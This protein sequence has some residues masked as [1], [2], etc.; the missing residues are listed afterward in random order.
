MA[1]SLEFLLAIDN[2]RFNRALDASVTKVQ[3]V[4]RRMANGLDPAIEKFKRLRSAAA[5]FAAAG[6]LAGGA[7]AVVGLAKMNTFLQKSVQLAGEQEKAEAR[8]EAVLRA[9]GEAAGFTAEELKTYA[10]DLQD[11]TTYGDEVTIS[12]MAILATF[13]QIKGDEFKRATRAAQ[14]MATVIEGMS[15]EGSIMQIG[16]ALNDPIKGMNALARAGVQFTDSQKAAITAM[17]QS[18]DLLGAQKVLLAELESQF[19]GA[20]EAI[21]GTF[22]GS[23]DAVKNAF[24]DLQEE[25]GF[26]ITQNQFFIEGLRLAEE[27][28]KAFTGE[29]RNSGPEVREYAKSTALSLLAMGEAG[30]TALDW[31]YRGSQ[32][33]AG[34]FQRTAAFALDVSGGIFKII[35]AA[36]VLT[37]FLGITTGA[38][39]D[40]A[41]EAEAAFGAAGEL[42]QKA[43]ENFDQMQ[44]GAPKIQ[45][46]RD[47]IKSFREEL[48]SVDTES[49]DL[50][51]PADDAT[52][53]AKQYEDRLVE[54]NGVWVQQQVEV[55]RVLSDVEEI[56]EKLNRMDGKIIDITVRQKV[57]EGRQNGGLIGNA[58]QMANGGAVHLRNMLRGGHFPG[59]GGG[60]RR[61]VIAED[62]EYM[63]DK[64]RVRD[65]GLSVVRNFHAGNYGAV[66][67]GL[68]QKIGQRMAAGG[69]VGVSLPPLP[70]GGAPAAALAGGG[71]TFNITVHAPGADGNDIARKVL[72]TIERSR[73][74]SS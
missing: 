56:E 72:S 13:K 31:I 73:R 12:A 53:A 2:T 35:Q 27:T 37:D 41:I 57:V 25:V 34:A 3:Q 68:M 21:R 58:L 24:G 71:D 54:V 9:T 4:G 47:A 11:L 60:D 20:S 30:L 38:T 28:I 7:A 59:F 8:L 46:A 15:F 69:G 55:G 32:G 65:A 18:G 33:I 36:A 23:L 61:H 17:Q 1:K 39:E 48:E 49:V 51:K 16:K 5:N 74:R 14:D 67:S 45:A 40:W 42:K 19:G 66:I 62:G 43:A 50:S 70:G 64:W 22:A 63:F 10:S 6:V 52:V 29:I 44:D 26:A